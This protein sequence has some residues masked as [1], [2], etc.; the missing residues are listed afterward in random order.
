MQLSSLW[1]ETD[2]T[3]PVIAGYRDG[4]PAAGVDGPLGRG[5]FGD[6]SDGQP[7]N[8]SNGPWHQPQTQEIHRSVSEYS[9]AVNSLVESLDVDN[10][11]ASIG[12]S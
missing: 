11:L 6:A 3:L 1:S 4:A 8:F 2:Q 5:Q 7:P 10:I 9:T 12:K